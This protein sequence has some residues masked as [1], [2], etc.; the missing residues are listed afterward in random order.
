MIVR[1][2]ASPQSTETYPL[3]GFQVFGVLLLELF[4]VA[5]VQCTFTP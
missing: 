4:N 2:E 3:K 5:P 1:D